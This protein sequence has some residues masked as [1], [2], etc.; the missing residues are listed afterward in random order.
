MGFKLKRI[1]DGRQKAPDTRVIELTFSANTTLAEGDAIALVYTEAGTSPY[2]LTVAVA[3]LGNETAGVAKFIVA[4]AATLTAN[5]AG[6][7]RVYDIQPDM[8]FEAVANEDLS[9]A[10]EGVEYL[11][12]SGGKVTDDPTGVGSHHTYRGVILFDKTG[13]TAQDKKVLVTFP[14]A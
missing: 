13:A 8:V 6:K 11:L 3:K 1:G 4:E 10:Q 9:S 2:G 7:V 12:S 14:R 5:T